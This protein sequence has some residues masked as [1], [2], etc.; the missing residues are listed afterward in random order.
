MGSARQPSP[1]FRL[2]R[3]GR[4][5]SLNSQVLTAAVAGAG[6][7]VCHA[8]AAP[9][10]DAPPAPHRPADQAEAA[11]AS[12][13]A[14][15]KMDFDEAEP[16]KLMSPFISRSRSHQTLAVVPHGV[17]IRISSSK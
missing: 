8:E 6:G 5:A 14:A 3:V 13:E 9:L 10:S 16:L 4:A 15:A 17:H 12:N 2:L 7:H 1:I 11:A